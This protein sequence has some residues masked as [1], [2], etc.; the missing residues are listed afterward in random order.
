MKSQWVMLTVLF[1][2][3]VLAV[4]AGCAGSQAPPVT[5]TPA[6]TRPP[7]TVLTSPPTTPPPTTPT[8]APATTI[9]RN[10]PTT[11]TVRV[12]PT[13]AGGGNTVQVTLTAQHIAFDKSTIT[14]PAGSRVVMTFMNLDAGVPHNFALYTDSHATT[15]IFVG[16][17]VT[18]VKTVTYSFN[19][20]SLPG[21]YFFRCDVHPEM[22]TGNFVVT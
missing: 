3:G 10:T 2:A 8:P 22:M 20:P 9:P 15:R 11:T 7:T 13:A 1:I 5:T 18:G 19:A 21:T 16:D 12:T 6:T 17:F 4:L 14:V